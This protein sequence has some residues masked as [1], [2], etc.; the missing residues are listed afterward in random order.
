MLILL[1]SCRKSEAKVVVNEE[2]VETSMKKSGAIFVED[3][4]IY[5]QHLSTSSAATKINFI[6]AKHKVFWNEVNDNY[7]D[8]E[9]NNTKVKKGNIRLLC[10][11][12][13]DYAS[14]WLDELD[15]TYNDLVDIF[16]DEIGA[17][18]QISRE[19]VRQIEQR[20][21]E[22]LSTIVKEKMAADNEG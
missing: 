15:K 4:N 22:K 14:K 17:K 19:R 1:V 16:D 13:Q 12:N 7:I 6:D 11:A 5:T 2:V 10:K 9:Y 21:F 8:I 3:D 18:F 20:A